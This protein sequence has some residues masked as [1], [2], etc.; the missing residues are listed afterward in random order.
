MTT[1]QIGNQGENIA[2]DYLIKKG[3]SIVKRNFHFGK[4]GEIDIIANDGEYLCFVEVKYRSSK[5][6][7]NPLF[8]ITPSKVRKLRRT[9]EGYLHINKIDNTPCRFD[10]VT[11]DKSEG[12][13]K[14]E[15]IQNAF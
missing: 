9:V 1:T 14:I 4:N 6:F 13:T 2:E 12:E 7:G 11:I 10:I 3:Y 8:S 15:L 5:E